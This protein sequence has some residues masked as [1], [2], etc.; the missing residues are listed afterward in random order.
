[1]EFTIFRKQFFTIFF[2]FVFVFLIWEDSIITYL[3]I[4]S[5]NLI[6]ASVAVVYYLLLRPNP[7]PFVITSGR[8]EESR[9]GSPGHQLFFQPLPSR[10]A[11]TVAFHFLGAVYFVSFSLFGMLL[12]LG[13]AYTCIYSPCQC[14]N[15]ISFIFLMR[16]FITQTA[17][18][19][20]FHG[21]SDVGNIGFKFCS[22]SSLVFWNRVG[23]FVGLR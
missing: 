19:R 5:L 10:R 17:R 13:V 23:H 21:G 12:S 2:Y 14:D 6:P 3:E 11:V 16:N 15:K 18:F 1:M 4:R 22:V 20:V 7:K 8:C 9:E